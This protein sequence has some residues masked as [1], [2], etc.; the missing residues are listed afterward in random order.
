VG[1]TFATQMLRGTLEPD[2]GLEIRTG[3]NR[4]EGFSG[5]VG[6]SQGVG[7]VAL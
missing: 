5:P 6:V 4:R 3:V 7:R 2:G 1:S